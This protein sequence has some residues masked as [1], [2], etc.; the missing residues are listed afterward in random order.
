MHGRLLLLLLLLLVLVL[1]GLLEEAEGVQGLRAVVYMSES[2]Y[3][4]TFSN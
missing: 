1:A 3:M 2:I 4:W